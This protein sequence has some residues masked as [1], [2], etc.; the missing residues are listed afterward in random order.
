LRSNDTKN[1]K[2]PKPKRCRKRQK[3]LGE[4]PAPKLSILAFV[5]EEPEPKKG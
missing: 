1:D 3:F 4:I 5:E 2:K